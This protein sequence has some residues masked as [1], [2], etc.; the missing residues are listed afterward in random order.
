MWWRRRVHK[1]I[2]RLKRWA[3]TGPRIDRCLNYLHAWNRLPY[4]P[5]LLSPRT[6]NELILA[7]KRDYRGDMALARRV[8]DKIEF[9]EWLRER[10]EWRPLIVP[11]LDVFDFPHEF[12]D[13][14]FER[15]TVLKPTHTS[16]AYLLIEER[17]RLSKREMQAFRRWHRQDHYRRMREPNYKG[18]KKR[19]LLEPLL[20]D[21]DGH[22]AKDYKFFMIGDRP[23]MILFGRGRHTNH[24]EQFYSP[25]WELLDFRRGVT[26]YPDP[27]PRPASLD[28]ALK[29]ASDLARP[30]PLCRIDLYLLPDGVI[31]AGEV[32]FFPGEGIVPFTPPEADFEMGRIARALI[33]RQGIS[34]SN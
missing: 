16:G 12:E 33:A 32:T 19:F 10:P 15:D 14:I 22:P 2:S 6:F 29:T 25:D 13:R 20:R 11:T 7:S 26:R 21:E 17:R 8:T 31:K 23:V 24:T 1:G 30:F 34:K 5:N 27:Y 9:K 3:P 4:R 28:A 18:A